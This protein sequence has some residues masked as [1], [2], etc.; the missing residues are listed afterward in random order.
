MYIAHYIIPFIAVFI[1][2]V[3]YRREKLDKKAMFNLGFLSKNKKKIIYSTLGIILLGLLLGN[4]VDL[5]HV[6]YR[7][8]GKVP[9]LGTICGEGLGKCHS[10]N[11]YPLHN[12]LF[13]FIFLALGALVFS[14]NNKMKFFGFLFFGAFLNLFLDLIQLKTGFGF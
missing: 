1:Y 6:Y 4:I 14:K 11:M 13:M 3:L 12:F 5:D 9:W 2:L 8:I 7:M 10:F